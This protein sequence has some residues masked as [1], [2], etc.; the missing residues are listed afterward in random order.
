M[1]TENQYFSYN[2]GELPPACQYCVRG[3]KLVLFVT[4]I[5]PRRCF[6]CPVSDQKYGKDARFA[7]ERKIETDED[8]LTEAQL[9]RAK[10]AGITGG[11]PLAKLERTVHYIRLLKENYGKEFHI[12][13]YTSL[14]LVTAETLQQLA[15][16]GLDE[17]RFHLDL[18]SPALWDRVRLA[19]QFPWQVG[20]ELPVIPTKE[21]QLKKVIDFIPNQ[22]TF[23]TLNELETADNSHSSLVQMGFQTKDSIS[24]AIKGSLETGWRLLDY[25]EEKKYPLQVHFCTA[26]LKDAIQLGNRL[27]REAQGMKKPFD[28]VSK[29]GLLTR[30]A[31]YLPD[32]VPGFGYRKKLEESNK[33]AY[34]E[35]L[36]PV[37]E[38]L[39]K[40]LHFKE[41]DF[42]LDLQKPRILIAASRIAPLKKK[43]RQWGLFRQ[44]SRNTLP[45]TSWRLKLSCCK[46]VSRSYT[47]RFKC[48]FTFICRLTRV[49]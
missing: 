38:K 23:L 35:T 6:F 1:V 31:L 36:A 14:N 25:V 21:A 34:V 4:G 7:N 10:G 39:Q 45:R 28:M 24:Y 37:I 33:A 41:K 43:F 20:V 5:C 42:Y 27:K 32:L 22:V 16:A 47:Q 17:I 3:E 29:E 2:Q 30:G 40:E 46:L 9:M 44:S 18:D 13:L 15:E 49:Y 8:I 11:D 26:R 12:H 19:Q 48:C